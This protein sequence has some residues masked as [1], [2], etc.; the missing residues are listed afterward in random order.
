MFRQ[1]HV[2]WI[3]LTQ[4]RE[5]HCTSQSD[6]VSPWYCNSCTESFNWIWIV[7]P[8]IATGP[9]EHCAV[10]VWPSDEHPT[11]TDQRCGDLNDRKSS[12]EYRQKTRTHIASELRAACEV[13]MFQVLYKLLNM[14]VKCHV[15]NAC[16]WSQP[17]Y[18]FIIWCLFFGLG[19]C[20]SNSHMIFWLIPHFRSLNKK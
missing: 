19:F 15:K 18:L 6:A 20:I 17:W 12:A 13:L 11:K 2:K 1:W 7:Q 4:W 5:Q 8:L 3:S 14:P 9:I 16:H 10:S